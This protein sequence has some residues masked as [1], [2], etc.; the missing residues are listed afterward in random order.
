VRGEPVT[1]PSDIYSLGAVLYELPCGSRAHRLETRTAP[2]IERVVCEQPV[3]RPSR[4]AAPP[5]VPAR[6]LRGDLDNIVLKTLDKDPARHYPTVEGLAG[7]VRRYLDGLPVLARPGSPWYMLSKFTRRNKVMVGAASLAALALAAG[8]VLALWQARVAHQE[9][10]LAERRFDLARRVA[11]SV[12]FEIHDEIASL[13]GSTKAR[14]LLLARSMQYLDALSAEA[15]SNP[16]LQRDLADGYSRVARLQGVSGVSNLG[17][18]AQAR[19]SLRKAL[20]LRER[21]LATDPRSVDFR[22]ELA[23]THREIVALGGDGAEM[24]RHAEAALSA[25]ETLL[26]EKPGEAGLISDCDKSEFSVARSLTALSRFSEA[27]AHYRKALSLVAGAS[28]PELALYHK[29]LGGVLIRTGDLPAALKEYQAAAAPDEE[30]VRS[31]PAD[32]RA[33]LALSY[34]YSDW[35]LILVETNRP[36]E[37][38]Q[39]YRKAEKIRSDM[40]AADPR[41]A[42]AATGLVSVSWRMAIALAPAGDRPASEA[43]FLKAVHTA[44]ELL[45]TLPDKKLGAAALADACWFFGSCYKEQWSSCAQARPW[46]VRARDLYRELKQ[47]TA[48]TEKALAECAAVPGP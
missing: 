37:A 11:G 38:V 5:D 12:L 39:Q 36:A 31:A 19:A 45:R 4:A 8:A 16:A 24:L 34:D 27:A 6:Q 46:I 17:N 33:K 23:L 7:D 21:V 40:V 30:R 1:T 28:S 26:R 41:D 43:A 10:V 20:E 13:A 44:E 25:V 32:G 47:P 2:E 18:P 29:S 14:E 48:Q 42:R 22:R 15:H 35:A 9:R 3:V